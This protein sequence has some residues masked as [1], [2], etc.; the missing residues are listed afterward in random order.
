MCGWMVQLSVVVVD[1]LTVD[2]FFFL[3]CLLDPDRIR[4]GVDD[5]F[6]G[7]TSSSQLLRR[8]FLVVVVEDATIAPLLDFF[9]LILGDD[10]FESLR[11]DMDKGLRGASTSFLLVLWLTVLVEV[12][13]I[14]KPPVFCEVVVSAL[15]TL[16]K[17]LR[18]WTRP[19]E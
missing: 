7:A 18:R 9:T 15:S 5:G 11:D 10:F 16:T 3:S 12:D 17:E 6:R 13:V 19:T 1:V 14:I 4:F 8:S 2:F